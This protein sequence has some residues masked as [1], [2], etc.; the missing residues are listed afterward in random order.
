MGKTK[1]NN[2]K[3]KICQLTDIHLEPDGDQEKYEKE[4]NLLC[5]ILDSVK[6]D[7]VTITSDLAWGQKNS[8]RD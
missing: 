1:Y 2:G 5:E 7:L 3:L 8:R 4:L 6:P